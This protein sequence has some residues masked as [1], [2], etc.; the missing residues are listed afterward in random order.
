MTPR[1]FAAKLDKLAASTEE[2]CQELADESLELIDQ[3][4]KVEEDP[5]GWPWAPRANDLGGGRER[6]RG[7]ISS[8]PILQDTGALRSHFVISGVHSQGFGISN[9]TEYGGYHQEGT[10]KMP[11]RSMVPQAGDLGRWAEPFQK[12]AREFIRK[13][14]GG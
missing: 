12:T 10:S 6:R 11:A 13:K 9:P 5:Y 4:F 8:R 1:Q 3:G 2:L 14:L 7:V